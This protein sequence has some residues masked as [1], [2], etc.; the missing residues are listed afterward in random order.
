MI[1]QPRRLPLT[2]RHRLRDLEFQ[3]YRWPG[4]TEPPALCLHGWG[5]T[6]ETWQFVADALPSTRSLIG[7]DARGFG[8]SQWPQEG[9]WFPD[10]LAD[11]DAALDLIAA[12]RPVDLIGHSMGANV[13]LIYAGVRPDRIRR[14]VAL[15]GVGL[16]RTDPAQAP[17]HY[18]EWLDEVRDGVSYATYD[19]YDQFVRLLARR[20]PRTPADRLEFIARAWAEESDDGR[21][22]LRADP[23]HKRRN[24]VLYQR[25]QAEACWRA[26]SAPVLLVTGAESEFVR[27]AGTEASSGKLAELF[28]VLT[29]ACVAAAGHMLHHEQPQRVAELIDDF[30]R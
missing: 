23:R 18:R 14:V 4:S 27:A 17:G 9:Y 1:Y 15:E 22:E 21:I 20:N 28:G 8:R 12:H 25:D 26:I 2:G 24:A 7:F 11:L 6:A 29:T 5:D 30:L 19:S 3:F 16:P 10:Y 13:A